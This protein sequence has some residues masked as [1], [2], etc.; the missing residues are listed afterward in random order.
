MT[1][2][3]I[4]IVEGLNTEVWGMLCSD[5]A[6][7]LLKA[8]VHLSLDMT[9]AGKRCWAHYDNAGLSE[10]SLLTMAATATY[11]TQLLYVFI[12]Y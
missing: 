8:A 2:A 11:K 12:I 10:L 5:T 9:Y 4:S 7:M 1:T 3:T 6:Q